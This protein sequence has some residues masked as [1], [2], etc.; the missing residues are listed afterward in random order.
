MKIASPLSVLAWCPEHWTPASTVSVTVVQQ[1]GTQLFGL[2]L[3][4]CSETNPHKNICVS[5]CGVS[6]YLNIMINHISC[7]DKLWPNLEIRFRSLKISP[8]EVLVKM[9]HFLMIKK[10]LLTLQISI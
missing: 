10:L 6:F 3:P 1:Y 5:V 2:G 4:L 8:T 9:Q 7:N